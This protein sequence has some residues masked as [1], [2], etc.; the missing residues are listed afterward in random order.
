MNFIKVTDAFTKKVIFIRKDLV[1]TVEEWAPYGS[2]QNPHKYRDVKTTI[3]FTRSR[4][5]KPYDSTVHL[6]LASDYEQI[7]ETCNEI[8]GML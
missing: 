7:T 3:T 2:S 8:V 5:H 4:S 6:V 1:Q